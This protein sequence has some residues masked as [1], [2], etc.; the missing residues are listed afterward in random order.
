[1]VYSKLGGG[2]AAMVGLGAMRMAYNAY[3]SY[4]ADMGNR[5]RKRM[6]NNQDDRSRCILSRH[7]GIIERT[8][9]MEIAVY[10]RIHGP[11]EK[12]IDD[13]RDR[14]HKLVEPAKQ[15]SATIEVGVI[16]ADSGQQAV[17]N[18]SLYS[19][20][21]VQDVHQSIVEAGSTIGIDGAR[22]TEPLYNNAGTIQQSANAF[23]TSVD[24]MDSVRIPIWKQKYTFKNTSN[25][26][27]RLQIFEYLTKNDNST[28]PGTCWN[29]VYR[30]QN[31]EMA[32]GQKTAVRNADAEITN[33]YKVD[34]RTIGQV[35]YGRGLRK[36]Y[37]LV[38][39]VKYDMEPGRALSYTTYNMPRK[40]SQWDIDNCAETY[41]AG[42]T[43]H[44]LCI[45]HGSLCS[46]TAN[47]GVMSYSN[48]SVLV[49]KQF[50][51]LGWGHRKGTVQRT[52]GTSFVAAE[53]EDMLD[54]P[55]DEQRQLNPETDGVVEQFDASYC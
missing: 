40:V 7:L 46:S 13:L 39:K 53:G 10:P 33:T 22:D 32:D 24:S 54:I 1:M 12:R 4:K 18:Y 11:F 41:M 36:Y 47:A 9:D 44:L 2:G 45:V 20:A 27:C 16:A 49:M 55:E 19:A 31:E 21:K 38:G 42:W 35:P 28:H 25:F 23:L 3:K 34:E 43:K 17:Q 50:K 5:A 14:I 37:R 8:R 52:L 51:Y 26:R 48:A 15:V 30:L 29:D 6:I